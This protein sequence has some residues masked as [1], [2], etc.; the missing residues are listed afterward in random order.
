V[1]S[2]RD[3]T[4]HLRA[5]VARAKT[6]LLVTDPYFGVDPADWDVLDRVSVPVRILTAWK[7]QPPTTPR[8]GVQARKWTARKDPI[9][10]HDRF[11]FWDKSGLHVG[12]SPSGLSGDR[13]FRIDELAA[14]E[15]R[16]L[17][18]RFE[19]WWRDSRVAPL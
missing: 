16:V 2:G 17:R 18:V 3:A 15:V 7:A 11:Y 10:Y 1:I 12:T 5:R 13:A 8:L 14:A 6:E 4:R 9:P 19:K